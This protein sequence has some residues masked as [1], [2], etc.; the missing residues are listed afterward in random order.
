MLAAKFDAKII[1][2]LQTMHKN[3]IRIIRHQ[4]IVTAN[5]ESTI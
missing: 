3:K 5:L 2:L 1:K 4:Q